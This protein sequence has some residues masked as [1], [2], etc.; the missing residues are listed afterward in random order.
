[1]N[2]DQNVLHIRLLAPDTV[3]PHAARNIA[4]QSQSRS[5]FHRLLLARVAR[6]HHLRPVAL[7]ELKDMVSLAGRQ[8]PRLV[9]N[10]QG[11]LA[12]GDLTLGRQFQELVH[13]VGPR[14]A[15][16]AQ[17]HRRAPGHR[18]RHDIVAVLAIQVGDRPQ[19]GG[20]ARARRALDH[21]HPPSP[22]RGET[23]RRYLLLAQGIAP[24]QQGLY[25]DIDRRRGQAVAGVG[26]H[27]PGHVPH[28]LFQPEVVARRIDLCMGHA[29]PGLGRRLAR[30]QPFDLGVAAQPLDRSSHRFPAHQARGRVGSSFHHVRAAEHS[31]LARQMLR[32]AV[33]PVGEFADRLARDLHLVPR[34]G[35]DQLLSLGKA[36]GLAP[37]APVADL[38][39]VVVRLAGPGQLVHPRQTRGVAQRWNTELPRPRHDRLAPLRP[40]AQQILR[41]AGRCG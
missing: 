30:L 29:G 3:H 39:V 18:R 1:M 6:K 37:P 21:R 20:L 10:D 16:V 26:G 8:H 15:V 9:D 7:R 22:R 2:V 4:D 28:R 36:L 40:V 33:E 13:A 32:Q 5:C 27:V 34:N 17:R 11:G 31:L 35:G 23:D 41:H 14:I 25:L 24:V 12:D 19:R 38:G